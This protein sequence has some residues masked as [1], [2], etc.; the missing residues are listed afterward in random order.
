M[1]VARASGTLIASSL[2]QNAFLT[3]HSCTRAGAAG[4]PGTGGHRGGPGRGGTG[5]GRDGGTS[6]A[7]PEEVKEI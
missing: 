3:L 5:G 6:F 1:V 4:A 7:D 2:K